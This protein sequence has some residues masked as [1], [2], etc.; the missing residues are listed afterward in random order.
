MKRTTR[1]VM[2][3]N[4]GIGSEYPI[5]IQSMLK[6]KTTDIDECTKQIKELEKIHCDLLRV[7][8]PDK[9]SVEAFAK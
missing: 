5:S 8:V 9:E 7:S 4:V 6:C 2:V 1:S 3:G